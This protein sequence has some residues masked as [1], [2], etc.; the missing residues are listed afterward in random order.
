MKVVEVKKVAISKTMTFG[1]V[2]KIY[3]DNPACHIVWVEDTKTPIPAWNTFDGW[4]PEQ[5]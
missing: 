2:A 1:E 3:K 4:A 5:K